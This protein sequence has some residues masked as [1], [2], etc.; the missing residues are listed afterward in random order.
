VAVPKRALAMSRMWGRDARLRCVGAILL[1]AAPACAGD[2]LT[3]AAKVLDGDT[4]ELQGR[5]I[6]LYV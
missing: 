3:G 5:R 6:D 4:L 2:T 1:T